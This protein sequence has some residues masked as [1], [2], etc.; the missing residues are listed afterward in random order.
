MLR[1]VDVSIPPR[2]AELTITVRPEL[3][4][5]T[6]SAVMEVASTDVDARSH[7]QALGRFLL[8]TESAAS[9]KIERV[10]ASAGP[11]AAT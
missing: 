2:I 10:S 3:T 7:S 1:H 9:S 5:I 6:E 4:T 8:R 11:S